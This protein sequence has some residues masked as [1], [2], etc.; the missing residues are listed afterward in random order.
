M[1]MVPKHSTATGD[2]LFW[3]NAFHDLSVHHL[4]LLQTIM[5]NCMTYNL[6]LDLRT[7]AFATSVEK[8][9][10]VYSEAGLTFT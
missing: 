5:R 3:P 2:M 7:A 9:F 1:Y 8:I 10:K 4:C 6:G